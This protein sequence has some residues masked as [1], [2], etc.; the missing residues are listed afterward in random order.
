MRV[1]MWGNTALSTMTVLLSKKNGGGDRIRHLPE[2]GSVMQALASSKAPFVLN[3]YG[4]IEADHYTPNFCVL[5]LRDPAVRAYWRKR[6][7]GLREAIGVSGIFLDSSFNLSS[8]KFNWRY[9]ADPE[10]RGGA[11]ID[12]ADLMG[13]MRPA[14]EPPSAIQS[15]YLDH[16]SLV[17][18]MQEMGYLYCGEDSGVFGVHRNG[19]A[20]ATR[21]DSL[22]LWREF[23]AGFDAAEC[24]QAG[25]DPDDIFFRGLAYRLMWS[26]RWLPDAR[27]LSFHHAR[28]N[29]PEDAPR[30]WHFA[31]Y[32][33]Y[34]EVE[35]HMRRR[36]ILPDEAGVRYTDGRHDI[37]WCFMAGRLPL[38][39]RRA[40]LNVLTGEA[41]E[42]DELEMEPRQIFR[43]SVMVAAAAQAVEGAEGR[44]KSNWNNGSP[45]ERVMPPPEVS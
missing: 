23:I 18:E 42:T 35:G 13:W 25:A 5:N 3:S 43:I 32:R 2:E 22:W 40:V 6:W 24:R 1:G 26:L 4:A 15:A 28:P 20:L 9:N 30:E 19:P 45:P 8:D 39:G 12:Q 7:R 34:N 29:P 33:A 41:R 27:C 37:V 36:T 16:L 44:V 14:Q 10:A 38:E 11:T 21:L 31:L 17:R